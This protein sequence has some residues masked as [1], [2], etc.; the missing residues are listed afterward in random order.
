VCLFYRKKDLQAEVRLINTCMGIRA[1][2]GGH[3]ED[4]YLPSQISLVIQLVYNTLEYYYLYTLVERAIKPCLAYW[5][6]VDYDRST[7]IEIDHFQ[8]FSLYVLNHFIV[9][10]AWGPGVLSRSFL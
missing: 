1:R 10:L 8:G 9:S 5:K 3:G 7:V 4:Y 2:P 6:G